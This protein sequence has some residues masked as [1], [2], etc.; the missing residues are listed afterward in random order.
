MNV[1]LI[2]T[3]HERRGDQSSGLARQPVVNTNQLASLGDISGLDATTAQ[4]ID[5]RKSGEGL[6]AWGRVVGGRFE[7]RDQGRFSPEFKGDFAGLTAG[8]DVGYETNGHINQLGAFTSYLNSDGDVRG[9]ALGI[10]RAAA[11]TVSMDAA[12]LG[13]YWTHIGPSRW[14]ID[15][16]LLGTRYDGNTKSARGIGAPMDGWGVLTSLE[17]GYP[18]Q[19]G[20]GLTLE[21]QAQMTWQRTW[22]DRTSDG[23]SEMTFDL[24]DA[25]VG[26]VGLRLEGDYKIGGSS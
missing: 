22:F 18:I 3:L 25:F 9:F 21:G 2:G 6:A 12:S 24:D 20:Q 26:R 11:G 19:L 13:L 14:Y 4:L 7:T 16:V 1:A 15:A 10:N 23:F 8:A 17:A 5:H